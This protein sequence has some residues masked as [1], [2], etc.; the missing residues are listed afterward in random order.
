MAYAGS[1]CPTCGK[2]YHACSSCDLYGWEWEYC[3]KDCWRKS[4]RY[5]ELEVIID[6]VPRWALKRLADDISDWELDDIAGQL[7]AKET[8]CG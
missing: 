6:A 4:D 7:I 2:K 1:T 3:S 8:E 5:A